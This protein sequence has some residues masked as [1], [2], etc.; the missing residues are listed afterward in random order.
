MTSSQF[1]W[2]A[3]FL[4][5]S[6]AVVYPSPLVAQDAK[7]PA[8]ERLYI[9]PFTTQTGSEKLQSDV[10]A[11]LRKIQSIVVVPNESSADVI[12]GGGG[13]IWVKGYRSLNPRSGRS[14]S[15]GTPVYDGFLSVELRDKN[16]AALW[17]Y[18]VTP[19]ATATDVSRDLARRIAKHLPEA[20]GHGA[21][22]TPQGP[23]PPQPATVLKGAGATF[24]NPVYAKWFA[25]YRRE[26]PGVEINYSPVGSQEGVRQ[27]L[28]GELDFAASDSPEVIRDLDPSEQEEY[29]LFP[30]VVGA[31]V[32]IVNL[33]GLPS[34][35]SL[36]PE[37]LAGIYLGKIKKWDD[38]VLKRTNPGLRLPNLD[39]VVVHRGDGS[40]TS[41][42]LTDYLS[43]TIPEWRTQV[44]VGLSPKWPT[45][46]PAIGN[47]G[48]AEL[49]KELGG[50]IGYVEFIYALK[51]H[52][53][54]AKVRNQN[55]EFVAGSLESMAVAA[56]QS[57]RIQ[58]NFKVSIV[59]APGIG[60][61]PIASFTWFILPAHIADTA[62]RNALTSF[63]NW[64]LGPGQ[65]QAAA[66]GY[67]A[68]PQD[69][70]S[71]EKKAISALH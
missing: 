27:L 2:H 56:S 33:P 13:E 29:L 9:E 30:S 62:K 49:V 63:L 42:A 12:L 14:T 20:L 70:V 11:E 55:G 68:L 19:G 40:G 47:E 45:G 60:A 3:F 61:Y 71:K 36:T 54:F 26:N 18:L 53:S 46:R 35:I 67:L 65:P 34:D 57:I 41:Y 10:A 16:G 52:L 24:P 4:C 31:V 58:D 59:N 25:N 51:N 7:N 15:N 1:R 50:S 21:A 38:P 17:S 64:M 43:Q 32:P 37:A 22:A 39:I 69:V 6:C 44:G 28:A 8:V 23:V 66:L 5:F 48:V